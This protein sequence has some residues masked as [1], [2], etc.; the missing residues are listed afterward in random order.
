MQPIEN[1]NRYIGE[2]IMRDGLPVSERQGHGY[3]CHAIRDITNSYR[4]LCSF[5]PENGMF[6]LRIMLPLE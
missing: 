3:G 1:K 2:I 4:G 5:E 6:T